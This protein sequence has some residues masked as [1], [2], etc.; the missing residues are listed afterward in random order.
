[1][2]SAQE[3]TPVEFVDEWSSYVDELEALEG[4]LPEGRR[5][6]LELTLEDLRN[7]IGVAACEL[8]GYECEHKRLG[9]DEA[10]GRL[11]RFRHV[12]GYVHCPVC[13]LEFTREHGCDEDLW[14]VIFD[15]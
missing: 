4:T 9:E 14:E 12:D 7:L 6:E 11:G 3:S 8:A 13:Y 5:G 2:A 15:V 10:C 1:M